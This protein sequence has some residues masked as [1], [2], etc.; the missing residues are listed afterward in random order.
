MLVVYSFVEDSLDSYIVGACMHLLN[1]SDI[2]DELARKQPLF[3]ILSKE[4]HHRYIYSLVKEILEKYINIT[5]ITLCLDY[6]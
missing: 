3:E 6:S 2:D 1:I 5:E 4:D